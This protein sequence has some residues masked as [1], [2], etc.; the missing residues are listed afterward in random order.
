[1][2]IGAAPPPY[3][4]GIDG[5]D[6]KGAHRMTSLLV[7]ITVIS[8]GD[9]RTIAPHDNNIKTKKQNGPEFLPGRFIDLGRLRSSR[10]LRWG[11]CRRFGCQFLFDVVAERLVGG[12]I[13]GEGLHFICGGIRRC[14][15]RDA[16]V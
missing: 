6:I 8:S 5:D 9:Y 11:L 1:M 2:D 4:I 10:S 15:V 12:L 7:V 16:V 13:T 14:R 3:R